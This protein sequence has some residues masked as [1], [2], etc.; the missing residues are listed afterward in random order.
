MKKKKNGRTKSLS[1]KTEALYAKLNGRVE[2]ATSSNSA[3]GDFSQYIY[4]VF[5]AKNHQEI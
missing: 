3:T 1:K 2:A 5:V 4:Y